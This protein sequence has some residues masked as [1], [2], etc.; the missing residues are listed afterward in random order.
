MIRIFLIFIILSFISACNSVKDGLTLKKKSGAD[1]FLVKKKNP[2]VL[3]PEFE[4]L[5]APDE[6][7]ERQELDTTNEVE[8]LLS[9]N[10]NKIDKSQV[11]SNSSEIEKNILKK[12]KT[13]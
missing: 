6:S 5:P 10:K 4:D 3:P 1:E 11:E 9:K 2:L 12:I 8:E 13:K 7:N